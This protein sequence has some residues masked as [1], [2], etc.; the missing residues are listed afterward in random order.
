[1]DCNC[2]KREGKNCIEIVPIFSN[3]NYEEMMEVARIT[4][5]KVFEKGEMIYMAGHR[6]ENLYVIHSGKVKITR[7]TSS[8]KEQVIRVLGPGEFM[9]ELSLFSHLPL[10]DNGEA[11]L[12]TTVCMIDGYRLKDL[13]KK[14]PAIALKVMEELS[15]RLEKVEK[16]VEN[17]SLQGVEK[18]LAESLINMANEKGEIA[19][20]MSKRDLASHLGM[21][22]ET[23]SRKLTA[24][25]DTGI[26]KLIGHR[27]ILLLDIEALENIE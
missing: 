12:K 18:R 17:I 22:Q 10:R 5:E 2:F 4:K 6:G 1:M 19:L 14:Y 26:I 20:K 3:L 8:G 15:Q 11:L 23:L 27:R 9:G 13:M 24:F 21:S 7:F 16:L 25:Q